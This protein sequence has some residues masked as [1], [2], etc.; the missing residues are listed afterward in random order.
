MNFYVKASPHFIKIDD[1]QAK[2]FIE[3]ILQNLR[4]LN[5]FLSRNYS[6]KFK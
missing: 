4:Y 6:Q 2:I 3:N 5:K 1:D